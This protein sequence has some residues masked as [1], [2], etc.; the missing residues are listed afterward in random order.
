MA[1]PKQYKKQLKAALNKTPTKTSRKRSSR[2]DPKTKMTWSFS[3]G[4]LVEY[5]GMCGVIVE[6]GDDG[7]YCI[8]SPGGKTW[9]KATKLRKIQETTKA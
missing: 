8:M 6:S 5:E 9:K 7:F 3:I 1:I 4:D 2:S